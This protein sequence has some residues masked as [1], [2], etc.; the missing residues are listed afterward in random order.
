MRKIK[1]WQATKR[2]LPLIV[3]AIL[4]LTMALPVLADGP[5]DQSG[6][7]CKG[8]QRECPETGQQDNPGQTG[9]Q[10]NNGKAQEDHGLSGEQSNNGT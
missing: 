4:A 8:Q 6:K 9:E 1:K 2:T 5:P 7:G 10:S 3:V